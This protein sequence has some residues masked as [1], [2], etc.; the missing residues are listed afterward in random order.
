LLFGRGGVQHTSLVQF[1]QKPITALFYSILEQTKRKAASFPV[2]VALACALTANVSAESD[3]SFSLKGAINGV[4][5]AVAVDNALISENAQANIFIGGDFSSVY[6]SSCFGLAVLNP[7]GSLESIPD[8]G[9]DFYYG[10]IVYSLYV[11]PEDRVYIGSLQGVTRLVP[12]L[13]G[14][15]NS[16][17]VDTSYGNGA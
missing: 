1:T 5:Y 16:W 11:D 7:D 14:T 10:N 3:L 15:T 17:V 8:L 9:P 13:I 6:G 2:G 12:G 4:V